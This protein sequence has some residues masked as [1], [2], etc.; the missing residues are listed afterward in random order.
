MPQNLR[1]R[2]QATALGRHVTPFCRAV[3][4][5]TPSLGGGWISRRMTE[6]HRKGL[7]RDVSGRRERVARTTLRRASDDDQFDAGVEEFEV[8]GF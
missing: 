7:S 1:S 2:V 8:I 5:V 4:R 3:R 6:R